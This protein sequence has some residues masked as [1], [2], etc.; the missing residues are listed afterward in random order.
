MV[1]PEKGLPDSFDPAAGRGVKWTARLGTSTYGTPVVAGGKVLIGTNNGVPRDPRHK[2][3]RGVL[4]C[5]DASSGALA[6]QLVVPKLRTPKW[7]DFQN[8]GIASSP[9]VEGGRVYLVT[10]RFEVACLDLDGLADG[11]DGP[12]ADEGRHMAEPGQA[13]LEVTPL[14]ADILWLCDMVREAGINP[15]NAANAA[16]LLDG[17]FLYVGTSNG[18]DPSHRMVP[19]PE[20][21]SLIALEKRTGRIVGRDNFGIGPLLFHGQWSSPSLGEAAGRRLVVFGGGNG[22][23]YAAEALGSAALQAAAPL[24]FREVWRFDCDPAGPKVNPTSFHNNRR[25]GPSTIIGSP[26]FLDGRVYVCAGGDYWHGKRQSWL[27]CIAADRSGDVAASAELWSYPMDRHVTATPSVADGLV[28]LT[29]ASGGIHCVDAATGRGV[30]RHQARGETWGSTLAADGRVYV[31]TG[32]KR[33]LVMAAG[34]EAKVLA[35]VEVDA[36]IQSTPVAADGVLCVATYRTLYAL[37]A[38]RP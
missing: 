15:H 18:V 26:V 17:E 21:P 37:H 29:D 3:D 11:N 27:K 2:G 7:G 36:P 31:G 28:Y 23:V 8:C 9:A 22:V 13:D 16:P 35:E 14:D 10:N 4:M 5:F 25:E 6:W 33:L 19:A 38:P 20:A 1:S 24:A 32:G 12:Y 34:R 30:W